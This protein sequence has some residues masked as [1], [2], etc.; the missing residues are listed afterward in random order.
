[1]PAKFSA[2]ERAAMKQRA[3][4]LK[5]AQNRESGLAAVLD[6]HAQMDGLDRELAEGLHA[7]VTEVAPELEP[8]TWY[9][10]P[11]YFKNG[12]NIV[13]FK[14]AA[15][16]NDRYATLGFE[17]A[18]AL[19]DGTMWPTSYALT[20]WNDANAKEIARLVRAAAA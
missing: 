13:F 19:D 5:A 18:A 8:R 17:G 4:E 2:E 10:F 6:A 15:K 1:M 9:G 20:A 14:P 3:A 7:I 11:A 12:K 16:F